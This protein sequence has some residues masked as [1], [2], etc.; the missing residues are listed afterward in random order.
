ML[1]EGAYLSRRSYGIVTGSESERREISFYL[2]RSASVGSRLW[3]NLQIDILQN[4]LT[5][6]IVFSWPY[7]ST[8]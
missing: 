2:C 4:R 5:D 1:E 3:I 8:W 7:Q 6:S